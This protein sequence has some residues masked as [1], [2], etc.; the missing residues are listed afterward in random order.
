MLEQAPSLSPEHMTCSCWQVNRPLMSLAG[1]ELL[2]KEG[3]AEQYGC[4]APRQPPPG[5]DPE[6]LARKAQ[7]QTARLAQLACY[8]TLHLDLA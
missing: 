6:V 3:C 1:A 5:T 7:V 8:L 2:N 4:S